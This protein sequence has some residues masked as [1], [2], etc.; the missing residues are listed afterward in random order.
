MVLDS[1]RNG[2]R[3]LGWK[4]ERSTYLLKT[5]TIGGQCFYVAQGLLKL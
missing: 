5:I 2:E 1:S 4:M 3:M